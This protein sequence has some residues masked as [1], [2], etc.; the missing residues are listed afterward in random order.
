MCVQGV[1]RVAKRGVSLWEG[2]LA[3]ANAMRPRATPWTQKKD[4]RILHGVLRN[5]KLSL[6]HSYIRAFVHILHSYIR[7]FVHSCLRAFVHS[8]IRTF[9]HSNIRAFVHSYNHERH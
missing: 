8:C 9:V 7:A 3:R 4:T 5:R 2:V 1:R 6:V